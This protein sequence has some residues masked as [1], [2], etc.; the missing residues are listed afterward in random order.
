MNLIKIIIYSTNTDNEPYTNWQNKLDMKAKSIVK[1]RL[2]RIRLGNFGDA[3]IIKDNT[4]KFLK[5]KKDDIV[6][7][8][9]SRTIAHVDEIDIEN[10]LVIVNIEI[11]DKWGV[12]CYHYQV[13]EL[14]DK[15]PG[16]L[17]FKI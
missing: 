17:G 16:T 7:T 5:L 1:N 9:N 13:L 8:D 14:D 11:N 10:E 2:D 4:Q 12:K 6:W 3:K 15:K